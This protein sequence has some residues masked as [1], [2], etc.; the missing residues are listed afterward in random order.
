MVAGKDLGAV[1]IASVQAGRL[2]QLLLV[3]L[4]GSRNPGSRCGLFAA[5]REI[6]LL[7]ILRLTSVTGTRS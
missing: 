1:G 6:G 3:V 7:V 4:N 5:K 2:L